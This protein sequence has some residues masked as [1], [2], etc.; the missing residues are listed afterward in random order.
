MQPPVSVPRKEVPTNTPGISSLS[1]LSSFAF[2][3]VCRGISPFLVAFFCCFKERKASA[4]LSSSER[5]GGCFCSV[6]RHVFRA[7]PQEEDQETRACPVRCLLAALLILVFAG[8]RRYSFYPAL[9]FTGEEGIPRRAIFSCLRC[10]SLCSSHM[11]KK[12][13]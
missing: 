13:N 11:D 6:S 1:S 2:S 12:Q 10:P 8:Y 5:L 3:F 7:V 9:L 4:S